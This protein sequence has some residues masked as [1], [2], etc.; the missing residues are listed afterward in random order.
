[1]TSGNPSISGFMGQHTTR[2]VTHSFW[3]PPSHQCRIHP[4]VICHPA[5]PGSHDGFLHLIAI[6]NFLEGFAHFGSVWLAAAIV[7]GNGFRGF[8]SRSKDPFEMP[9]ASALDDLLEP[10]RYWFHVPAPK[11]ESTPYNYPICCRFSNWLYPHGRV[12]EWRPHNDVFEERG[13]VP[14][15]APPRTSGNSRLSNGVCNVSGHSTG[16]GTAYMIPMEENHWF[17]K[18]CMQ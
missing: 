5:W 9:V 3:S 13:V 15:P 6:D 11:R 4:I 14:S 7:A 2:T 1:M 8:L 16:T 18:N 10:G 17:T 12:P